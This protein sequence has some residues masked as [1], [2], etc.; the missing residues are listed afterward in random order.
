M[1]WENIKKFMI[2][3]LACANVFLAFMLIGQRSIKIYDDESIE[4]IKNILS[5]SGIEAEEKFLTMKTEDLHIYRCDIPQDYASLVSGYLMNSDV[6]DTFATPDSV[7]FFSEKGEQLSVGK[8][9]DI[10]Y[11]CGKE[12]SFSQ[13]NEKISKNK[14]KELEAILS[15]I[16]LR[17]EDFG[18]IIEN[19]TTDG[20]L[21]KTN[22]IQTL[23]DTPIRN[24]ALCCIFEND[25]VVSISGKWCFLTI[26][27]KSSAH[28][29]DSVNI[30]FS[31]KSSVDIGEANSGSSEK[32]TATTKSVRQMEQCYCS[33]LSNDSS[34]LY[35]IPSWH[36]GWN[37][38]GAED[39][40]FNAV[41]GDKTFFETIVN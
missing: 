17:G 31:E 19:A 10:K 8:N 2:I 15:S 29:L 9:F 3:L 23:M 32:V 36:I 28:L 20:G 34:T 33:H 14:E 4:N 38:E 37:E 7:E 13:E 5:M 12:I 1:N 22:I 6:F 16:L 21:I 39:S 24:H 41:N 27:E 18:L 25:R 35:L 30:L 26:N 40:Y 11:D